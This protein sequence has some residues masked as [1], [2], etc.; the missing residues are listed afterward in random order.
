M[1]TSLLWLM[2]CLAQADGSEFT[3]TIT[4]TAVN[5]SRGHAPLADAPVIL[6]A[7]IEGGFAPIAETQTDSRGQF[8]FAELPLVDGV[9][10]LP[11]V[12]HEDV[13]YPGPRLQLT[14]GRPQALVRIVAHDA[15]ESPNPLVCRRAEFGV[16][17]GQGY[18]EVTE[19]L[20]IAN[21]SITT[22]IGEPVDDR[23]AVTL[24]LA[25]PAGFDKV[26]FDKEALGRN[27]LLHNSELLSTLP[28]TPGEREVRFRYR[29]PVARSSALFERS[30][31]LPTEHVLVRVWDKAAD[32]VACSLTQSPGRQDGSVT[33]EHTGPPLPAG[34]RIEL[35][36]GAL[37][38][39]AETYARWGAL[40][41]LGGL[42]AGAIIVARRRQRTAPDVLPIA[43]ATPRPAQR[44]S[45]AAPVAGVT[46]KNMPSPSEL[47]RRRRAA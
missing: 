11:G 7:N 33:F 16:R 18:I 13:H 36:L 38:L 19:A 26:T 45:K 17:P 4:G 46:P 43:G 9:I 47:R 21:P 23:P 22:Y 28:W 30:L 12:N 40:L 42:I 14:P 32:Q 15:V 31:D 2:L 39:T 24:R 3:G 8:T 6:R 20:L 34:E 29:L 41:L 5:G 10:Y 37:P 44:R 27:F 35:R 25:L 1:T